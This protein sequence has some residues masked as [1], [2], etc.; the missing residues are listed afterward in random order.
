MTYVGMSEPP[1]V[2]MCVQS[3]DKNRIQ[4]FRRKRG[5]IHIHL[6][7]IGLQSLKL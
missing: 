4:E 2:G 5:Q 6:S 1:N 3:N 7:K